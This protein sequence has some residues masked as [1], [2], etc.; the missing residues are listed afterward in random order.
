MGVLST[1]PKKER[2]CQLNKDSDDIL[3]RVFHQGNNKNGIKYK[4]ATLYFRGS[5]N[6]RSHFKYADLK[7]NLS[8]VNKI[9][10]TGSSAGGCE[11]VVSVSEGYG[12]HGLPAPRAY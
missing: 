2:I 3:W 11:Y 9:V 8:A 4:D 7:Y 5:V 6:I 1:D 12:S 10:L